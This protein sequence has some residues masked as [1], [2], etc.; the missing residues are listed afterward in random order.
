MLIRATLMMAA[1]KLFGLMEAYNYTPEIIGRKLGMTKMQIIAT[2]VIWAVGAGIFG[3]IWG[4]LLSLAFQAAL[5]LAEER[6]T[7]ETEQ[8]PADG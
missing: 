5:R 8:S 6:A 4:I 7:P 3:M 1:A 2:V